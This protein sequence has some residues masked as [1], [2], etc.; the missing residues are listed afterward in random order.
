MGTL[1]NL[2]QLCDLVV[3]LGAIDAKVI[4]THQVVVNHWVRWKCRFGCQSYNTSLMCPPYTPTP[5]ETR[6]LLQEYKYGIL[7]RFK[8]STSRNIAAEIER[9]V[10]L[11]GYPAAL[12][13]TYGSCHVCESCNLEAG[14]CRY[15]QETRPSMESCGINVF[16]TAENAGYTMTVKTSREEEY[17]RFGLLLVN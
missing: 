3:K 1:E 14:Y 9:Q 11:Q 13:L 16:T 12:A 5:D 7:F 17:V 4:N 15:P 2:E 10:F 6:E 8:S